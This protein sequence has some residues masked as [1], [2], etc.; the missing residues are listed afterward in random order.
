MHPVLGEVLGLH[1]GAHE[2]R[3]VRGASGSSVYLAALVAL[4]TWGI[5]REA[6]C[7]RAHARD[8][9]LGR[10]PAALPEDLR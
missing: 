2:V 4:A 1:I 5:V 10:A 7:R 3:S 9:K 8:P 6:V